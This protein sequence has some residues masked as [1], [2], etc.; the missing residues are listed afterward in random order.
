MPPLPP[1]P[2][3]ESAPLTGFPLTSV[4]LL[5]GPFAR[6][7]DSALEYLLTLDADRLCAPYLQEAGL[8]PEAAPYGSWET[9]GLGGHIGGHYLS[10]CAQ[11]L[12]ATGDAR[13]RQR[14]ERVLDV[15]Q[16]CQ[17]AAGTGYLGG[18][19]R[20]QLLGRELAAGTVAADLFT[21]NGRWVPLYNLHKTLAG[22]LDAYGYAGSDR[23]LAMAEALGQWWL[24]ST[25][26][27]DDAVFESILHTEYGGMNDAFALLSTLTGRTDFR[28][29]A[30][31]FA[32]RRILAPLAAG[33]DELDGLHANTQIPKAVGYARLAGCTEDPEQ[34]REYAAAADTFFT[35]VRTRRTVSIGGNSVREHFHPA[36]DFTAMVQDVQGPETCNT[37]NMLKLAKLRFE[38]TGDPAAVAYY[39]RAVFNHI[40]SSQHP[41]AGGF[42]YFTPMRPGHYRVYS[43]PQESMWCCVGS[44]LENHSRYGELIFSRSAATLDLNL[45]LAAE[46]QWEEQGLRLRVEADLTVSDTAVLTV[47]AREPVQMTLRLR[48]PAWAT[49]MQVELD[50]V[51]LPEAG[52]ADGYGRRIPRRWSGTTVITVRFAALI[53]AE[54][55]PDGSPWVSF[56]YGPLVLAA[57]G[58]GT[59]TGQEQ[60]VPAAD[61]A[62]GTRMGH[63]A[64][65]PAIPLA[66]APVVTSA[67][68]AAAVVIRRRFP[69][70]AELSGWCNGLPVSVPL[71]PFADLPA[72]RYTV[73]FPAGSDPAAVQSRLQDADREENADTGIID[74]VTAGEQQPEAD[75][76]FAGDASFAG[77]DGVRHWRAASGWFSY[78]LTDPQGRARRVRLT[79]AAESGGGRVT[80]NGVAAVSLPTERG[81]AVQIYRVDPQSADGGRY[82]VRVSA[83]P[84][85]ATGDLLSM[86][87]MADPPA[88]P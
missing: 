16:R 87:L 49:G 59:G 19:P 5:P 50:G 27:L 51:L 45:Y 38:Q 78:T 74:A 62:A 56:V 71:V 10:S 80:I 47:H 70:E 1:A 17:E 29:A 42:A 40:L 60:A 72:D 57:R 4:R 20:G 28:T 41:Q 18:V 43:R 83:L 48:R 3:A 64:S 53:S 8:P 75:H 12:A 23:A 39:E 86:E 84:G 22:L 58:S 46:L 52:A 2:A 76:G 34:R 36:G 13:V 7:Q 37:Y 79:F 11:F 63:V 61:E 35:T 6:A 44:G 24:D 67:D 14:L 30:H 32:H 33:R 77:G 82:V 54:Y 81:G 25:S 68:P 9:D 73:Y 26:E 15:F 55:L 66:A 85:S 88:V 69:L 65:G 31:R 21:L